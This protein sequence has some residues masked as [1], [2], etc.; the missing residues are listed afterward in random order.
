MIFGSPSGGFGYPKTFI[1]LDENG[2]ELTGIVVDSKTIFDATTNDVREGKVFASDN[3]VEIGTKIIPAYHIFEG[4]KIITSGKSY[5][6]QITK[7]DAY[8]YTKM[9]SIICDFNTNLNDSVFATKIAINNK[10]YEVLSVLEVSNITK[11]H[12]NKTI[13]FGITNTTDKPIIIRYFLYKEIE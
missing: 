3:G 12:E 13:E 7:L 1:L 2:N 5:T 11:N 9:Q 6:I 10:I 4:Y 8:D